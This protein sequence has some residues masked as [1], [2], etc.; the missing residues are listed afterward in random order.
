MKAPCEIVVWYLLPAIRSELAKALEKEGVRQKDI[1]VYFGTTPA[2]ISQYSSGKR[3]HAI[4]FPDD[5]LKEIKELAKRIDKE[6]LS[7]EK[8]IQNICVLCKMARNSMVLCK[9]HKSVEN[10]PEGCNTCLKDML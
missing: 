3:G 4:E 8:I 2:A 9:I 7:P 5:I 6:K 10:V 1:A